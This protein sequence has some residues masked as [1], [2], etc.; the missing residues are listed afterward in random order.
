ML[1]TTK[2]KTGNPAAIRIKKSMAVMW[3]RRSHRIPQQA[4]RKPSAARNRSHWVV[5]E[6]WW[7]REEMM[8]ARERRREMKFRPP[9][10]YCLCWPWFCLDGGKMWES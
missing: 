10:R 1:V 5:R 7:G 4:P 8:M 2:A 9:R 3:S 6:R